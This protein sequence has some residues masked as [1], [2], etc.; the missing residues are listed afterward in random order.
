MKISFELPEIV[1][2]CGV[3][4]LITTHFWVGISTMGLG[5][6]LAYIRWG[7]RLIKERNGLKQTNDN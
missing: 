7:N 3:L 1:F 6:L 5:L 4:I 2:I